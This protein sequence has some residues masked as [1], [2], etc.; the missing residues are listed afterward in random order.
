[1]APFRTLGTIDSRIW[2]NTLLNCGVSGIAV[3]KSPMGTRQAGMARRIN[4]AYSL[5]KDEL[6]S[7]KFEIVLKDA[8]TKEEAYAT[9]I[10]EIGHILSGHLGPHAEMKI[11]D[12]SKIERRQAEM[13][14]ESISYLVCKRR[15][16]ETTSAQYLSGYAE[17]NVELPGFSLD[18]VLKV[19]GKIEEWGKKK[20]RKKAKPN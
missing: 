5:S 3:Y 8:F 2:S 12:N 18:M 13:E 20:P 4:D 9:L 6:P 14:A 11:P 1:M 17:Q 19:A 7:P 16:I 15:G 10:H